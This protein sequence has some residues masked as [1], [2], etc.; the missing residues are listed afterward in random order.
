MST[1]RTVLAHRHAPQLVPRQFL[2]RRL[3]GRAPL[4]LELA[5]I[6]WLFWLY[7]LVNGS[8]PIRH[9]LSQ[10]ATQPAWSGSSTRCTSPPN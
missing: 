2:A 4:W 1:V 8:A 6:G 9:A 3:E 10:S 5:V 7:D